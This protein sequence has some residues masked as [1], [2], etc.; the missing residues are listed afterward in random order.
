MKLKSLIQHVAILITTVL[1]MLPG[2]NFNILAGD[3]LQ[4]SS[5]ARTEHRYSEGHA[6]NLV[7]VPFAVYQVGDDKAVT[8]LKKENVAVFLDGIQKD[9]LD[10]STPDRPL[11]V[12]L[13]VEYS[14]LGTS[15][16]D[17]KSLG[18]GAASLAVV[19]PAGSL[20]TQLITS[21]N[22]YASVVAF[23]VRPTPMTDL[24]NDTQRIVDAINLLM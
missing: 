23:D 1:A 3:N 4:V 12:A 13:L 10:F 19:E 22:D 11:A 24:T 5:F 14:K 6:A 7:S 16:G 18:F 20:L 8:N 2:N 21:P 9:I 15:L 17:N